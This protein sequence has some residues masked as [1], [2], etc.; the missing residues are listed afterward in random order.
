[1]LHADGYWLTAA[2]A[3]ACLLQYLDGSLRTP[4]LHLQALAVE[5]SR[6]LRDLHAMGAQLAGRGVDVADVVAPR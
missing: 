6:F 2:S 3:A 4:G 5:P 1:M